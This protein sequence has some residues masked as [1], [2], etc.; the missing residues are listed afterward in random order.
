[1]DDIKFLIQSMNMLWNTSQKQE[2]DFNFWENETEFNPHG[3]ASSDLAKEQ[4]YETWDKSIFD[5][6][7]IL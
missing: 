3:Q 2:V 1:M 4:S 6:W 7:Y 5:V